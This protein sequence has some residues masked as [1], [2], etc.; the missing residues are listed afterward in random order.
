MTC[1]QHHDKNNHFFYCFEIRDATISP[2]VS[3]CAGLD[4]TVYCTE[5]PRGELPCTIRCTGHTQKKELIIKLL[6]RC[7]SVY[8]TASIFLSVLFLL[9][10]V[11]ACKLFVL[12]WSSLFFHFNTA[13][14][15][16]FLS[17]MVVNDVAFFSQSTINDILDRCKEE[18]NRFV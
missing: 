7:P 13:V 4:L 17:T 1:N 18:C 15:W 9:L 12:V 5:K 6:W 10:Y 16:F 14:T 2:V 11:S 8:P 3:T